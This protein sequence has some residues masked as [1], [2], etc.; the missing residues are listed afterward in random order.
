MKKGVNIV[1]YLFVFFA[2]AFITLNLFI[3]A[4]LPANHIEQDISTNH[5]PVKKVLCV[6]KYVDT[7]YNSY[8]QFLSLHDGVVD[9]DKAFPFIAKD[10]TKSVDFVTQFYSKID[11]PIR[12]CSLLI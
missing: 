2:A 10:E 8:K 6:V 7:K 5:K 1:S 9:F 4:L 12:Y 11:F 3:S